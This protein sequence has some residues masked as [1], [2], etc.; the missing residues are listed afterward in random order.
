MRTDLDLLSDDDAT[1]CDSDLMGFNRP[2]DIV[3]DP[4]LTIARKRQLLAYWASDIHA[5]R[6][7]PAL[8]AYAFGP[9]VSI[10]DIQ[11]ALSELD[12]MID[13][14]IAAMSAGSGASF[15]GA[16]A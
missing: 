15:S 13:V 9:A 16:G 8:R 2:R 4:L 11:A 3:R 12:E 10:D 6:N 7:A 14:P 1:V 5:V